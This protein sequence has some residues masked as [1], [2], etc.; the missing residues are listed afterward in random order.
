M[1]PE[2]LAGGF[3]WVGRNFYNKALIFTRFFHNFTH[4]LLYFSINWGIR[5]GYENEK[6]GN[7][8]PHSPLTYT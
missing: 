5:N 8:L 6:I 1:T 3:I 4:P 7:C 2:E